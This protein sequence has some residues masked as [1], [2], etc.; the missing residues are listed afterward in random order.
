MVRLPGYCADGTQ[1]LFLT[2]SHIKR[3]DSM[4]DI[5]VVE[6]QTL[7]ALAD[8]DATALPRAPGPVIPEGYNLYQGR[9]SYTGHGGRDKKRGTQRRRA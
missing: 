5:G 7:H 4:M 6:A 1:L 3:L 2:V 8:V 9:N